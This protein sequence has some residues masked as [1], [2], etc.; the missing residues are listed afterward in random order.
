[1]GDSQ[2]LRQIILNLASNAVKFTREGKVHISVA[3]P[4]TTD[5][6]HYLQLVVED[7][8]PGMNEETLGKLFQPFYQADESYVLQSKG[9]GLGLPITRELVELMDGAIQVDS[10]P[11]E[12]TRVE[13]N[14]K[15]EKCQS[16]DSEA[17][18]SHLY[19]DSKSPQMNMAKRLKES[20]PEII[21]TENMQ[22]GFL[23]PLMKD[24]IK[25]APIGMAVHDTDLRYM[26]V[27]DRYLRDYHI[28]DPN[29]IGKHH[30]EVVPNIP[31][32]WKAVHQRVLAGEMM[33]GKEDVYVREDG[34]TEYA[35]WDCRPWYQ[36]DGSVGGMV[37]YTELVTEKVHRDNAVE[38]QEF[39]FESAFNAIQEGII[40]LDN[41]LNV[42]KT[43]KTM[44]Q[45]FVDQQ[46][47]TGKNCHEL[48]QNR[49][50]SC[51][52]C[53]G[54]EVMKIQQ[55]K[56]NEAVIQNPG[57]ADTVLEV[58]TYPMSRAF[59]HTEGLVQ[60]VRDVT[61]QKQ[62]EQKLMEEKDRA[63]FANQAKTQFL[64][65]MSHELRTPIN[66]LMGMTQ[67]LKTTE[68]TEEQQEYL[69]YSLQSCQALAQVVEDILN[70][71]SLERKTQKLREEPFRLDELLQTVMGLH[72]T[73][74][75]QKGLSLRV[76]QENSLASHLIGDHFKLKQ[77]L[78]ILVGNAVKFTEAGSV[79]LRILQERVPSSTG[80]IRIRFQV[81]DTGIGIDPE[82]QDYIFQQFAQSD[83]SHT[84][85]YGG[86]GL[87]LAAARKQAGLLGGT[88]T[89]ESTPEQGSTFTL[90]CEMSIQDKEQSPEEKQAEQDTARKATKEENP[91]ALIVD[92][93]H[94]SRVL[95]RM[96]LKKLGFQ[97]AEA[98]NGQEALK[99]LAHS[100][101]DLI[102]MDCQMPVMNGYEATRRIREIEEAAGHRTPIIA[103]TAKVLPGDQE[104][105]LE[106]GMDGFMGKP[107]ELHRLKTFVD[108][109][110]GPT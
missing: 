24:V 8:G 72:Q 65:N 61:L 50:S 7:T 53:V 20:M 38:Q 96:L 39:L 35:Q 80:R 87:G 107:I 49:S 73:A 71:T 104:E 6:H 36:P 16:N 9:T 86:L 22:N 55:P 103:M 54:K 15:V 32:K 14:L 1:M 52:V 4:Q 68:L 92:D 59:G 93:D 2:R 77:I 76:D 70:Y 28:T 25:H 99:K 63:E 67:L 95:A 110:I 27:S 58:H 84:R 31:E 75:V 90:I 74:A 29:I 105:C 26:F 64:A 18:G 100:S 33:S 11:G 19:D 106:A 48:W 57:K 3:C 89:V 78:G 12:G 13:V 81:K 23:Y 102:L 97:V 94:T 60:Y 47:L 108:K 56:I 37:L 83:E 10:T 5:D 44:N 101:Y 40:V 30:Y 91:Q 46:P 82:K 51:D 34:M 79:E 17:P 88:I 62:I 43:N 109:Y 41:A 21:S 98:S 45:W 66:G 69:N 85:K 42:V